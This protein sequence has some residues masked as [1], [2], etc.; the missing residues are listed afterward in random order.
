M[1]TYVNVLFYIL[2]V[3]ACTA[4]AANADTLSCA[5]SHNGPGTLTGS[6]WTG[7]RAHNVHSNWSD[8]H[9]VDDITVQVVADDENGRRYVNYV[10]K[11]PRTGIPTTLQ[12]FMDAAKTFPDNLRQ[13]DYLQAT[14]GTALMTSPTHLV[15]SPH[16]GASWECRGI[17]NGEYLLLGSVLSTYT[18]HFKGSSCSKSIRSWYVD[19]II[20]S[21]KKE[22]WKIVVPP[23]DWTVVR[24]TSTPTC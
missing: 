17:T 12:G 8:L 14:L 16:P 18:W 6:I 13:S 23:D 22:Q 11:D 1:R 2:V 7:W 5:D 15:D 4:G 10:T 20:A 21:S 19:P 9:I 24:A 3:V